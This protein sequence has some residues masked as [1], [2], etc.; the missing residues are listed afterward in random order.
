MAILKYATIIRT[1]PACCTDPHSRLSYVRHSIPIHTGTCDMIMKIAGLAAA[2]TLTLGFSGCTTTAAKKALN[3]PV[4]TD[5]YTG[6]NK[7]KEHDSKRT[8]E[9]P[10]PVKA[11]DDPETAIKTLAGYLAKNRAH[12][13]YAEENLKYWGMREG[14]APLVARHVRPL[15]RHDN[16]E[17]RAPALRLTIL[18]GG[19]ESNGDLIEC[20][21]D[22][23]E[24]I[25]DSAFKSLK[26]RTGRDFGYDPTGSQKGRE[27]SVDAWRAWWQENSRSAATQPASVYE[28]NPR[29]NAPK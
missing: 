24:G 8:V 15:L 22:K 1:R 11:D 3:R 10:A 28:K 18:Y 25:R 20:L 7:D 21:D 12:I 5:E 16:I 17:T 14:V 29:K 13:M 23:D 19:P 26:V 4:R 2:L 9:R 27:Q 6:F